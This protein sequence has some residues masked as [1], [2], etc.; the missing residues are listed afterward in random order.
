MNTSPANQ[1]GLTFISLAFI[2]G[3]IGF[4]VLLGLK[5]GPV[6]L[7]HSK[8]VSALADIKK[9]PDIETQSEGEIRNSLS[10]RFD[11]NYVDDVTQDDITIT[12]HGNY[13]KVV[14]EYE[15]ARKIAGNLSVLVEFNDNIEVGNQ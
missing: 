11:I 6:Y 2:L 8:V 10:K 9:T 5:I 4:F 3:L 7:N 13:I 14:I 1:Q 15:V 12:R